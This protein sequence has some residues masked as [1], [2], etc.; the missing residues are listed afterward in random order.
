MVKYSC[1]RCGKEFSQK[2]HYDSHNRRKTPCENNT[3]MIKQLVD[4]AVDKAVEK[5]LME[6]NIFWPPHAKISDCILEVY[7]KY[8]AC[9]RDIFEIN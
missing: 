5:K 8:F 9:H 1:K 4:K 2:S 7:L 6:L 3:D